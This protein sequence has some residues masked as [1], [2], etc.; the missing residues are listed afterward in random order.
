MLV[1][2]ASSCVRKPTLRPA[3][4]P[5]DSSQRRES[6]DKLARELFDAM[7][8]HAPE[9]VLAPLAELDALLPVE[10][11][12]RLEQERAQMDRSDTAPSGM[13]GAWDHA[14]YLGFCA[15]GGREE[16]A[17]GVL[18]LPEPG[19]ILERLLVA[20]DPGGG[21]SAAWVE[22]RFLFTNWGWRAL[23]LRRV[24][25]PRAHHSDLDLA[26]CD[27]EQGIR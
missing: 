24:E 7:R 22:G 16:P 4:L 3:G 21:R 25:P 1:W 10:S 6:L 19:W 2:G 5:A 12:L 27:V 18:G 9:R 23:T 14:S 13:A 17:L 20:A 11:R 26:P 8:A 15:Q